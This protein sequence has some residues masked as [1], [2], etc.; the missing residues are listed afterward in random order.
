MELKAPDEPAHLKEEVL[1]FLRKYPEARDE[2]GH[3]V[4]DP[5]SYWYGN[6]LPRYFWKS[7]W[8]PELKHLGFDEDRFMRTVGAHRV[9]FFRWIEGEMEWD[10]LADL[11][12]RSVAKTA[13]SLQEKAT[14]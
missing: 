8:G 5:I 3:S 9:G 12:V 14:A 4:A 1:A 13:Q 11:V 2:G 10:R 6:K 7:G